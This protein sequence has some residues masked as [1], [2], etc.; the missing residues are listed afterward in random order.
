MGS[1]YVVWLT[2]AFG[3]GAITKAEWGGAPTCDFSGD[4]RSAAGAAGIRSSRSVGTM[5]RSRRW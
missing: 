4:Y 3:Y 2:T 5:P 1:V